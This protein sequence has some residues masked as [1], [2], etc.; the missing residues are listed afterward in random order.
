MDDI[1][2]LAGISIHWPDKSVSA[3]R[4]L[5][6]A[7]HCGLEAAHLAWRSGAA[8]RRLVADNP[9]NGGIVTQPF[10]VVHV[11]VA[12][13][14]AKHRPPQHADQRVA[15]VLASPRIGEHLTCQRAQSKRVVKFAIGQQSSIGGERQSRETAGSDA[16][17]IEPKCTQFRFTRWVRHRDLPQSQIIC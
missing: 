1:D 2:P 8:P 14:T 15:T 4:L 7:S 3:E 13:E 9:A 11:L 10:G 17:E 16:V 6:V 5:A 12:G